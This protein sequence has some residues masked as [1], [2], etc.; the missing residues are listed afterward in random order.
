MDITPLTVLDEKLFQ[1]KINVAQMINHIFATLDTLLDF[2]ENTDSLA[3]AM[4]V[5]VTIREIA[6]VIISYSFFSC[7]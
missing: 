5:A 2:A 4:T 6:K 7:N 1:F 3:K